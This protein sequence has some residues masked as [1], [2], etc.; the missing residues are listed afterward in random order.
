[1]LSHT[2]EE[3]DSEQIRG[4]LAKAACFQRTAGGFE[5]RVVQHW[6]SVLHLTAALPATVPP[7]GCTKLRAW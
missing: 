2:P 3:T 7:V 4:F 1:M 5:P 6:G